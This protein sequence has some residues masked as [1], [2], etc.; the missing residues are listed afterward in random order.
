MKQCP[1]C[2]GNKSESEFYKNKAQSDGLY[3]YCKVCTKQKNDAY[4]RSRGIKPRRPGGDIIKRNRE[5]LFKFLS[6]HPC[7]D[8]ENSDI[9]VLEFDHLP[10]AEK[11]GGVA[12]LASSGFS[13]EAL[14]EEISKCEVRCRN[15]H[16]IETYKRLGGSWHDKFLEVNMMKGNGH[17]I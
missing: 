2:G 14:A 15:C 16:T 11:I 7:V 5:Y 1:K 12:K 17:D 9:R 10:G 13:L 8:C 4:S 6:E 3:P